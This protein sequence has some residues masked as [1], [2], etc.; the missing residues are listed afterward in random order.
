[1]KT[2]MEFS[3]GTLLENIGQV[4]QLYADTQNQDD[5]KAQATLLAA[6]R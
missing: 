1:M 6:E 3:I 5:L 4:V 2:N